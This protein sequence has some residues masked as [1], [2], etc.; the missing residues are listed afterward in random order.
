MNDQRSDYSWLQHVAIVDDDGWSI[1]GTEEQLD[2][3]MRL[4]RGV[5]A[6]LSV[7]GQRIGS[8]LEESRQGVQKDE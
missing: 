7:A 3:I 2:E 5:C 4:A 6:S 8:F 1:R